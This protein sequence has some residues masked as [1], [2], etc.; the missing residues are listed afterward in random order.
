MKNRGL[1]NSGA[2]SH[3]F[4]HLF[5][6]HHRSWFPFVLIILT[7]FFIGFVAWGLADRQASKI[8]ISHGETETPV[9]AEAYRTQI[10]RATQEYKTAMD[11][12]TGDL[13]RLLLTEKTLER[14]LNLRVPSQYKSLHLDFAVA[15]NL[16]RNG[17]RGEEG[18]LEEG[19]ERFASV[20]ARLAVL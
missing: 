2:E 20:L 17:L 11:A 5:H 15:L 13:E 6:H 9:D 8:E 3:M 19:Q 16:I 14:V 12:S 10:K 4:H 1:E 7:V 18:A